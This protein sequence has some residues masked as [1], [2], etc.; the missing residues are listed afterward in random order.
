MATPKKRTKQEIMD[1]LLAAIAQEKVEHEARISRF[2]IFLFPHAPDILGPPEK[3]TDP[4][5]ILR[6]IDELLRAKK[7]LEAL[8]KLIEIATAK[9]DELAEKAAKKTAPKPHLKSV[10]EAR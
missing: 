4:H 2:G 5:V 8:D 10:A 7:P 6:E 3:D 9:R 1:E